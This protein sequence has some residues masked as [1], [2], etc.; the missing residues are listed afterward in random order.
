MPLVGKNKEYGS[1]SIYEVDVPSELLWQLLLNYRLGKNNTASKLDDLDALNLSIKTSAATGKTVERYDIPRC[2][3]EELVCE[4]E[5]K[6]P[7]EFSLPDKSRETRRRKTWEKMQRD[8][9]IYYYRLQGKKVK[10]ISSRI[11][12]E[13]GEN[14]ADRNI[15]KIVYDVRHHKLG[16]DDEVILF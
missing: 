11:W 16:L 14:L 7:V 2:W 6:N 8:F 12:D 13:F 5:K 9:S 3:F 1:C 10:E 15:K 4:I